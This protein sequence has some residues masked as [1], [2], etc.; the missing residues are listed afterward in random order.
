MGADE[1]RTERSVARHQEGMVRQET[2]DK[3]CIAVTMSGSIGNSN[4]RYFIASGVSAVASVA[5]PRRAWAVTPFQAKC[6][7]HTGALQSVTVHAAQMFKDLERDTKGAIQIEFFPNSAL[8]TESAMVSQVRSG[9]LDFVFAS[10]SL[11]VDPICNIENVGFA[12]KD[13][14]VAYRALDGPLGQLIQK[15]LLEKSLYRFDKV[16]GSGFLQTYTGVKPIR[17]PDDFTGLKLR[18]A[19]SRVLVNLL[20]TLSASPTVVE[21]ANVY[22]S[23]Q[24]HL[25]DGVL[26]T[27][28]AFEALRFYEVQKYL[29]LMNISFSSFYFMANADLWQRMP[30][31]VKAII[32]RYAERYALAQRKDCDEAATQLAAK[33]AQQG[34]TVNRVDQAAFRAR[35]TAHYQWCKQLYGEDT[36]ALL[37]VA[38]GKLG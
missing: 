21:L 28:D 33:L 29:S 25:V 36:W 17:A 24:T 9:A 10:G 19:A 27:M 11:D 2:P 20:Q 5:F 15:R 26:V 31:D 38:T 23:L 12:F 32:A 16:W 7:S 37:E 22:V 34:M 30:P 18:V 3:T 13:S 1:R 14:S 35:C 4:R 8:G 6:G